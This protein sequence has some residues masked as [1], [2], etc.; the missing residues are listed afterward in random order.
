ML[1]EQQRRHARIGRLRCRCTNTSATPASHRFEQIQKF[2]DPPLDVCPNAAR[3]GAQAAR[4]RRRSSSRDRLVHH[5]L[6]EEVRRPTP[7]RPARRAATE[8]VERSRATAS[9]VGSRAQVDR[10]TAAPATTSTRRRPAAGVKTTRSRAERLR[11]TDLS[12]SIVVQVLAERLGEIRPPQREVHH[13]L[14]ESELVAGVVADAVDLGSRRSA[15]T[16]AAAAGRWSAGFR[17]CD[18]SPSPRAPG[19]CRASGCSGR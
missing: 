18:R 10:G 9:R 1:G 4:R 5:R 11:A 12:R 6:R 17:R 8:V 15:A 14:Q 19:R 3:A 16:S 2:S 13:R 7:A